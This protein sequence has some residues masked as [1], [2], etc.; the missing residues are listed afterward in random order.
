MD[1]YVHKIIPVCPGAHARFSALW[2]E[3]E[4]DIIRRKDPFRHQCAYSVNGDLDIAAM[5]IC[6]KTLLGRHDFECFS[7][8][9]TQVNNFFCVVMNV[10]W[11]ENGHLLKFT[12][13]ADRFLRNMVRAVV[14]T[15]LDVGRGKISS[16]EFMVIIDSRNRSSAGYSVPAKGLTLT[17]V[18]YPVEI[19]TNEPVF[20][21]PESGDKI[22]SHYYTDS[23]FHKRSGEETNE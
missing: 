16:E 7:K 3:Y 18:G 9:H 2:R 17:G 11:E 6:T 19:F 4:Y 8:V 23:E 12:I 15:L 14:G 22:I 20:F 21:L 1:I 10:K 5:E 13:R